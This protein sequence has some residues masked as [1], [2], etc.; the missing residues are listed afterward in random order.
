MN[1]RLQDYE[2]C[3]LPDCSTEAEVAAKPEGARKKGYKIR[4]RGGKCRFKGR[5]RRGVVPAAQ[6]EDLLKKIE[7]SETAKAE[8]PSTFKINCDKE[9]CAMKRKGLGRKRSK[10]RCK[11]G[12]CK[13]KG[14]RGHHKGGRRAQMMEAYRK[15]LE[16]TQAGKAGEPVTYK[17]KCEGEKCGM[18]RKVPGKKWGRG[19][20]HGR[21]RHGGGRGRGRRA[22]AR[23][24]RQ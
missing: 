23:A 8:E 3:E 5:K 10:I 4:C 21:R 14:R 9:K 19:R 24:T 6:G 20:R 7:G 12:R 16:A 17:V 1:L 11:G 13:I 2:P 15:R 22:Y 18:K